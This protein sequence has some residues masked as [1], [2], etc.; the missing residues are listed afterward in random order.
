MN[1]QRYRH[2]V[3]S[4]YHGQP[5]CPAVIGDGRCGIM[6]LQYLAEGIQDYHRE[7]EDRKHVSK[8]LKD[9]ETCPRGEC[10]QD[11]AWIED[12]EE[13]RLNA[14]KHFKRNTQV[15]SEAFVILCNKER[16]V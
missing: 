11:N 14:E 1:Q 2:A 16:L 10:Q 9:A 5:Y 7:F 6:T 13:R 8:T 15:G 4:K 12:A 3:R